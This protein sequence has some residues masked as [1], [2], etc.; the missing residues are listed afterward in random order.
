MYKFEEKRKTDK[1]IENNLNALQKTSLISPIFGSI[2]LK[3]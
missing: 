1:E 3:T 2:I